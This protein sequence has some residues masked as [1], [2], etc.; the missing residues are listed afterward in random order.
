MSVMRTGGAAAALQQE[1][2][3][4]RRTATWPQP[5]SQRVSAHARRQRPQRSRARHRRRHRHQRSMSACSTAQR[6]A[7][8]AA[9]TV[10][11]CIGGGR[12]PPPFPNCEALTNGSVLASL[13]LLLLTPP[14]TFDA[15]RSLKA[16]TMAELLACWCHVGQGGADAV[17]GAGGGGGWA[18]T[19]AP[20]LVEVSRRIATVQVLSPLASGASHSRAVQDTKKL[21]RRCQ[22]PRVATEQA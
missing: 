13:P 8:P 14:W 6:N 19:E 11:L 20:D 15:C 12:A 16:P 3:H 18:E 10:S 17:C 21:P 7:T 4:I 1:H 22:R 9:P 5:K 2:Q